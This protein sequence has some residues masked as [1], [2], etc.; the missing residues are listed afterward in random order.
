MRRWW[1][2][3]ANTP[4]NMSATGTQGASSLNSRFDLVQK[5]ECKTTSKIYPS[6]LGAPFL[7]CSF[8]LI[9]RWSLLFVGVSGTVHSFK[10]VHRQTHTVT[11]SDYFILTIWPSW[12]NKNQMKWEKTWG[13]L[14]LWKSLKKTAIW[15]IDEN[16]RSPS[17]HVLKI[18]HLL[19]LLLQYEK[20][21]V[22]FLK[23]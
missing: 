15:W 10:R 20:I 3:P 11:H 16:M 9:D 1:W 18:P 4:S 2:V 8:R 17:R 13:G 22:L 21:D 23:Y 5:N 6:P 7:A 12:Q 19:V 14:I